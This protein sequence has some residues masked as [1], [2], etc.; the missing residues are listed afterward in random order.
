MYISVEEFKSLNAKMGSQKDKKEIETL[1]SLYSS[2]IDEYC[3]T[4]FEE[5]VHT[6]TVD[7]A[8]KLPVRYTPLIS[9]EGIKY[10]H[11]PL[12]ENEDY[13]IYEDRNLIEL[14]GINRFTQR[15][16]SLSIHYTYGFKEVPASVKKAIVDL[17]KLHIEGSESNPLV[18][19]ESFDS[20]YSYTKN[21][22]KTA[23]QLQR[24]ILSTLDEYKQ[25]PY[26][27]I[28]DSKGNVRARLL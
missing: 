22:Q 6:F 18:S 3:H 2:V 4:K 17:V 14:E 25:N 8:S 19:Q 11:Q 24:D 7:L 9:V 16:K 5:T 20:E 13:Y 26:K 15:K 12:T 27:P 1:I 28:E 10:K 21:T 23:E